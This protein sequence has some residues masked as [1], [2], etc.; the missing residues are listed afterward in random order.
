M[1]RLVGSTNADPGVARSVLLCLIWKGPIR[2]AHA[3]SYGND[4]FTVRNE[5]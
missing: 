3:K 4:E 2:G 5:R 1:A